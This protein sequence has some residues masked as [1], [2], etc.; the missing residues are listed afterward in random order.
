M[1]TPVSDTSATHVSLEAWA[2]IEQ[3]LMSEVGK[4]KDDSVKSMSR[5]FDLLEGF[6]EK[7]KSLEKQLTGLRSFAHHV[8]KFLAQSA[9]EGAPAPSETSNV[10]RSEGERPTV[11]QGHVP[12]PR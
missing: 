11:S 9:G 4:V 6:G 5:L 7:Q 8:E 3:A 10:T 2:T 1:T 12:G